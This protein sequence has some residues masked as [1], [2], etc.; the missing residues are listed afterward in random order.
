ML[1][2][3]QSEGG[4][5][6]FSKKEK[7]EVQKSPKKSFLEPS[8]MC[9]PVHKRFEGKLEKIVYV[10]VCDLYRCAHTVQ[11]L[12]RMKHGSKN[13]HTVYLSSYTSPLRREPSTR[14]QLSCPPVSSRTS[15]R[16]L[17]VSGRGKPGSYHS[18]T[19]GIR[20]NWHRPSLNTHQSPNLNIPFLFFVFFFPPFER[21]L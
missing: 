19:L 20:M 6:F 1:Y 4:V 18:P 13:V 12:V 8:F 2:M 14:S 11:V 16:G 17:Q 9:A 3:T 21:Q 10:Q 7:K 5:V 15:G